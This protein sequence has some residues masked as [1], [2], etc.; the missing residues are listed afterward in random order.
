MQAA[1]VRCAV[2]IGACSGDSRASPGQAVPT[3]TG[4]ESRAARRSRMV[5]PRT[6]G[7]L[8]R[9]RLHRLHGRRRQGRARGAP[10]PWSSS[11]EA[12]RG[13]RGCVAAAR[14]RRRS[15][16]PTISR[17]GISGR[18]E[19]WRTVFDVA[20]LGVEDA[21]VMQLHAPRR[22]RMREGVTR[23]QRRRDFWLRGLG[24]DDHGLHPAFAAE[25][26]AATRR[27]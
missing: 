15:I 3:R 8:R 27:C 4:A 9:A 2:R 13:P 12:N 10:P 26:H 24:L 11:D 25:E 20:E 1:H 21:S 23:D 19:R 6:L 22:Q 17:S 7:F 16:A 5:G 14:L 18:A